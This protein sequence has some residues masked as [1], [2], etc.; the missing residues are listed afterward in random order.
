M[1]L[2]CDEGDGDDGGNDDDN[3]NFVFIKI[4]LFNYSISSKKKIHVIPRFFYYLISIVQGLLYHCRS[5]HDV[6]PS[7]RPSNSLISF[8][9][10]SI[11]KSSKIKLDFTNQFPIS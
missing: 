7:I 9:P 2:L 8:H 11:Q 10:I 3:N 4:E 1:L 5:T 6:Y